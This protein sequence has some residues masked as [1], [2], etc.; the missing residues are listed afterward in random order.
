VES[1]T[2]RLIETESRTVVTGTGGGG[3]NGEMLVK[4]F[5][6]PVKR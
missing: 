6:P 4:G 2:A 1:K 5:K 3:K